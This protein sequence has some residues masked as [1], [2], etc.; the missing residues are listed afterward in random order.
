MFRSEARNPY[1]TAVIAVIARDPTPPAQHRRDL[2]TPVIAEIGPSDLKSKRWPSLVGGVG[3]SIAKCC[4]TQL[5]AG[6]RSRAMAAN[7][8][9][10]GDFLVPS[11]VSFSEERPKPN[12][13][14]LGQ[15]GL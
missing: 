12:V 2:G 4:D 13:T 7:H 8:D 9:D 10:D 6:H 15:T 1:R 3:N 11:V 14:F 5:F